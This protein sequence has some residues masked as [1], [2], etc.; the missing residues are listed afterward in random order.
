M[1]AIAKRAHVSAWY[2]VRCIL[3]QK[4]CERLDSSK[5][6]YNIGKCALTLFKSK[7][8]DAS[9]CNMF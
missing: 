1:V 7:G 4:H 2:A 8:V 3:D 6:F 9:S 5:V